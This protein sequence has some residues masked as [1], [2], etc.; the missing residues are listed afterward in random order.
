VRGQGFV[1]SLAAERL[2]EVVNGVDFEC[3]HGVLLVGRDEDNGHVRFNE[4]EHL[5]PVEFRHLN[6]EEEEVRLQVGRCLDRLVAVGTLSH[7]LN[8]RTVVQILANNAPG[9]LFVVYNNGPDG[10][11][12]VRQRYKKGRN[13]DISFEDSFPDSETRGESAARYSTSRAGTASE[14]GRLRPRFVWA[15]SQRSMRN[16][17]ARSSVSN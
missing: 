16:A 14:A 6:I 2:Q 8:V 17:P 13:S 12:R 3:L 7:D 4:F 5:E 10:I 9:E 1:K 15:G 11:H